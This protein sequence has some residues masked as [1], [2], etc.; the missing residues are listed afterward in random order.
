MPQQFEYLV[1]AMQNGRVTFVN[2]EWQGEV[3]PT[4][5]DANQALETCPAAWVFLNQAG[6]E[7]WD[8]VS[9]I[10]QPLADVQLQTLFLKRPRQ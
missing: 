6:Q 9:A 3:A 5:E 1:C 8:L 2:G 7:G 4:T 10:N